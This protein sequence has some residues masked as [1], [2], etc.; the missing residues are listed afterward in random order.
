[1][2]GAKFKLVFL[3]GKTSIFWQYLAKI[4]ATPRDAVEIKKKRS[5]MAGCQ[6]VA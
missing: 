2:L 5:V 3:W 6:P 4:I 1:M